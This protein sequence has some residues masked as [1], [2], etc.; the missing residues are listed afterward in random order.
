MSMFLP[1]QAGPGQPQDGVSSFTPGSSETTAADIALM[2]RVLSAASRNPNL[3]PAD[4]M[5]YLFDFMQTQRLQVPIGQISG[6][7]RAFENH[8]ILSA[9]TP[10][11]VPDST[12]TVINWDTENIDVGG[13]W[14]VSNKNRLTVP[15]G[16]GG[17]YFVGAFVQAPAVAAT[18]GEF[19]VQIQR[20]STTPGV[21][22]LV[23]HTSKY[24]GV[25]DINV[26][27]IAPTVL[28]AG[29]YLSLSFFQT[30][31]VAVNVPN[32]TASVFYIFRIGG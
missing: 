30:T 24:T 16:M 31:G 4:F 29:D 13:F 27:L 21:G 3:I 2:Q 11:S 20:N 14:N 28:S 1:E 22:V 6:Y 9:V 17:T 32:T 15:A 5:A 25:V 19:A 23:T 18:T 10:T 26:P 12:W 8:A 7:R